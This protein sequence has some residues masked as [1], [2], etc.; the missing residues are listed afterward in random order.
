MQQESGNASAAGA[1]ASEETL[2]RRER[3]QAAAEAAASQM[4]AQATHAA[5]W[6]RSRYSSLDQ[7][8]ETNPRSAALL[9]LGVGIIIGL[10]LRGRR[11]HD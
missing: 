10:L 5:D 6:A 3:A 1:P 9:A 4:R 7:R 11:A 2:S 8:L